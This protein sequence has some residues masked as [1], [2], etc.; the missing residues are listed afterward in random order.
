MIGGVEMNL[1]HL[2]YAIEIEKT[3]SINKAAENLYMGQPNLSRAIKELERS[4]GVKIFQRT[5]KG[6]IPTPEGIEFLGYA[7]KI[8]AQVDQVENLFSKNKRNTQKFSISVPRS[9]Y[10]SSAF[11]NFCSKIDEDKRAEIYYQETNNQQA[12]RN[13]LENDFK[14]GI[15]RYDVNYEETFKKYLEEK[16]LE[17]KDIFQFKYN[18]VVSKNDPLALKSSVTTEDLSNYIIISHADPYVPSLPAHDLQKEDMGYN[19]ERHIFVYERASQLELLSK[20]E[21]TCM[22]VSPM[23]KHLLN[24]YGLK[25]IKCSDKV[26][27]YKDVLIYRKKQ[28]LDSFDELF[29][30]ELENSIKEH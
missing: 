29:I 10:I 2:K 19:N 25:E 27:M 6:M 30:N 8:L 5:S 22:F 4:M 9:S 24:I 14:M 18:I 1:L 12:I 21:N 20:V 16:K 13:I 11:V 26:G 7:K 23:P 17:A 3:Q 15:V 28:K